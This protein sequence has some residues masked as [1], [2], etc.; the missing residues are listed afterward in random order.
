MCAYINQSNFELIIEMSSFE[1]F[2]Y[3]YLANGKISNSSILVYTN[4]GDF[5]YV[6]TF[7]T[8]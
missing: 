2:L 6:K 3:L 5:C 4:K 8:F 1:I 7:E